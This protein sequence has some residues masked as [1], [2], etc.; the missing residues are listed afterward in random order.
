MNLQDYFAAQWRAY[1]KLSPDAGRIVALLSEQN[2]IVN[3]HI[4]LRTFDRDGVNIY[5]LAEPF[6]DW[7]YSQAGEYDF[8]EK[9]LKALH[10]EQ[11]GR[12]RI[13]ISQI[14]TQQF[15]T[16]FNRTIDRIMSHIAEKAHE[17][18]DFTVSGRNWPIDYVTY[19]QLLR[20]SEY[21]AWLYVFGFIAN[22][23]TISVNHLDQF[24]QLAE[25]NAFLKAKGFELNTSG[26]EIKGSPA[27]YLEQSS[28]MA[29]RV[30]VAFEDGKKQIGGCYY[31][32]AKR[33]TLPNGDSAAS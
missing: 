17:Q 24:S 10:L 27:E 7:G 22:H 15:S 33:Y 21:A 32:F 16:D 4:A 25:L 20:E 9:K 18:S 12:P 6:L 14:L 31:E 8:T 26:G 19:Q 28:T 2:T 30:E 29:S 23:F 1:C 5:Q 13:F 3:D 11:P